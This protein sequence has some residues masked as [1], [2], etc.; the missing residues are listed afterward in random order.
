MLKRAGSDWQMNGKPF[1][2]LGVNK[3]DLFLRF[4]KGGEERAQAEEAMR[5]ASQRGLRVI[6]FAGVGFYPKDMEVWTD[7]ARY[8]GAM[9]ALIEGAKRQSLSLIPTLCW[10]HYLFPDM[11]GE[12][13]QDFLTRP[14]SRS[15][16]FLN[17]Y[18]RQF[19][20]RYRD[21]SA[22]LFWEMTNELNLQ[23]DL[24]FMRPD[25]WGDLNAPSLGTPLKR[26]AR[27]NFTTDQMVPFMRD[28]ARQIRRLDP[29][30]LIASGYS[31]PRPAAQHLR[32]AK[33]KGDWTEDSPAELTTYLRDTHPDPIEVVSLHFYKKHDNLRFGNRQEDSAEP[34]RV[35]ASAAQKIGKPVFLG[36]TGDDYTRSAGLPFLRSVLQTAL[37]SK[38][39]L[40]LF[41]N[42][43][44]PGDQYDLSPMRT[45]QA[46]ELIQSYSEKFR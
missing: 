45:P 39:P 28:W 16:Q 12:T 6:R 44:S 40:V 35:L 24:A 38:I 29:N 41:W 11:A 37:E 46:V 14:H 17:L 27:D 43:M 2:A 7:E 5:E 31:S 18:T 42:W 26:L 23:A 33:G 21:E 15:R 32:K 30:H 13:V 8:W 34:L 9:D 19:V 1:R 3:F 36:E 20:S 22:I 4:L 10:N 25:G